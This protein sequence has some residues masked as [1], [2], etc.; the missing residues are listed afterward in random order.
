MSVSV[1]QR[2]R[3]SLAQASKADR[4][5]ASYMLS[6]LG[7]LP[8]ETAASLAEKVEVSEPT[9][10]RFCRSIG[11]QSFKDLKDHLKQDIGDRPWLISDR[12]RDFQRSAQA[13]E[14]QLGK[15]LQLEIAGLV[16]VYE[17]AQTPESCA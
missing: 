12:L 11:Y 1:R 16:A 6:Q 8:F 10:G 3:D 4:A 9:V 13:G 2:L 14:D 7:S 17:L 5:I 15:G